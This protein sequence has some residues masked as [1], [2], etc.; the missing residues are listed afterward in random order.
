MSHEVHAH[1]RE[2]SAAQVQVEI[3][4]P[5]LNSNT[6]IQLPDLAGSRL[7]RALQSIQ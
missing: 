4:L 5:T 2:R 3:V 6:G 7:M 1:V